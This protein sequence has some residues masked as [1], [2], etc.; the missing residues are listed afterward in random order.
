MTSRTGSLVVLP[1]EY[2]FDC[3][4][5]VRP[6][7]HDAT[8]TVIRHGERELDDPNYLAADGYPRCMC[9]ADYYL[10]CPEWLGEGS[11]LQQV[12]PA[13]VSRG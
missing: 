4:P 9:G 5:S 3:D 11:L 1:V 12:I 2:C 8:H 7:S 10:T 6:S 13:R